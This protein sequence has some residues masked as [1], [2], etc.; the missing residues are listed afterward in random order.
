MDNLYYYIYDQETKTIKPKYLEGG[1]SKDHPSDMIVGLEFFAPDKTFAEMC[2]ENYTK[3]LAANINDL[4]G[5]ED[6]LYI[7]IC[8]DC[9]CAFAIN[10]KEFMWFKTRDLIPPKRCK[11]CR[12]KRK[13][14]KEIAENKENK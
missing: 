9:S 5:N 11:K 13:K 6:G 8:K 1:K 14:E 10:H 4:E 12:E 2:A 3:N 7:E